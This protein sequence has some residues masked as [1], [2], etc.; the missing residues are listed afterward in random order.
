MHLQDDSKCAVDMIRFSKIGFACIYPKIG[1]Y[2]GIVNWHVP[3]GYMTSIYKVSL[4]SFF[5]P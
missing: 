4:G 1:D 2:A 3:V 5:H